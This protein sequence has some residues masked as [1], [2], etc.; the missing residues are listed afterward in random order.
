MASLSQGR[1]V[2]FGRATRTL[3]SSF[4]SQKA[5]AANWRNPQG[6]TLGG[7][8]GVTMQITA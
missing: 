1:P 2:R 8:E 3:A 5:G 6:T 4:G 7:R